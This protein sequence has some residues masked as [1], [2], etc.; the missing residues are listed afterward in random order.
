M[1]GDSGKMIFNN[2]WSD[3]A[4]CITID[5]DSENETGRFIFRTSH[6]QIFAGVFF[7]RVYDQQVAV[8][9]ADHLVFG[10]VFGHLQGCFRIAVVQFIP[11]DVESFWNTAPWQLD[12]GIL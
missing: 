9:S 7:R 12:V 8:T 2:D 11:C 4:S 1:V 10:V 3:L 5:V 6:H